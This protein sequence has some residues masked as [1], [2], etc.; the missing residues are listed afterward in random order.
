MSARRAGLPATSGGHRRPTPPAP[1]ADGRLARRGAAPTRER[2]AAA[3]ATA[4]RRGGARRAAT[5]G[6]RVGRARASSSARH[7]WRGA[8]A[9]FARLALPALQGRGRGPRRCASA[10]PQ[11]ASLGDIAD[12]ARGQRRGLERRLLR[13]ARAAGGAQRR[14]QAGLLRA[15]RGHELHGRA[16]RAR[17][18]RAAQRDDRRPFPR[19]SRAARSL[20]S[21]R[22]RRCAGSYLRASRRN[23]E[24]DPR[25]YG[26][27]RGA[28]L[29]GFLFPATYELQARAARRAR[30]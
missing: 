29:E 18:G 9:W 13:A 15:A 25:R 5:R 8:A 16:R 1:A 2:P 12:A 10:I 6:G 28:S 20:R 27:P 22:A 24:L 14:P 19:G 17:E 21:S 4:T 30:S 7:R 3:T 26:A 23:P 11:G